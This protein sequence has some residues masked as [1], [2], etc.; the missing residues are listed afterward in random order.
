M[1]D[2]NSLENQNLKVL[3][4]IVRVKR[5]Q[6]GYSLRDLA[7][8]TNISHTL[9]SN[10][11]Q[12]KI[13]PN[14]DTIA[15]IFKVLDL[16]YYSDSS[17]SEKFKKLYDQAMNYIEMYE[18]DQARIIIEEIEHDQAIYENSIEAVNVA[19]IRCLFYAISN[20]Y[21]ADFNKI[22]GYYEVVLDFFTPN[23]KQ[24]YY[25]IK[26]LDFVNK[27][28]FYEARI[29]FQKA[30]DLGNK[31][32]DLLIY[33]YYVISLSKAN[34]YVDAG[35]IARKAIK[36]FEQK[37]NYIRAMRLRTRIAYDLYR[38]NKFEE[39]E[40][41]YKMVLQ[42]STKYNVRDLMDRCNTRLSFLSFLK[43]DFD[44]AKKY[45]NDVTVGYNRLYHYL[46]FDL[47]KHYGTEADF[48]ALYKQY[49]RLD[50]VQKSPKTKLFFELIYMRYKPEFMNKVKFEK[51]L[52]K[53]IKIGHQTDDGEMIEVSCNML[54]NFYQN[55]RR[56]KAAY[57]T[58]QILLHY[59]K[60][61]IESTNYNQDS[62]IKIYN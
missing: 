32:M 27:E 58:V 16:H 9:I 52:L 62:I 3:G 39:S 4:I 13:V 36:E 22:L 8:L 51:H 11:E 34:K 42:F 61:G 21:F 53:L 41:L 20:M 18:Y 55:E 30:L 60:N 43:S 5:N 25:F 45:L 35:I 26:G 14:Q 24:M 50:W 48:I 54:A 56:Y 57:E 29:H 17:I 59:N 19:I 12:G 40:E 7:Q 31:D 49:I 28:S 46:Q 38:I 44:T 6:L 33:E 1:N 23:Q 10:F 15:D 37:T 2:L 47:V